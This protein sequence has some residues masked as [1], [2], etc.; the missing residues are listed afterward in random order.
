MRQR[1]DLLDPPVD[2]DGLSTVPN[3]GESIGHR[4]PRRR[5]C[6]TDK[7]LMRSDGGSVS[8]LHVEERRARLAVHVLTEHVGQPPI[9]KLDIG[10]HRLAR[11]IFDDQRVIGRGL[12][13]VC[14]LLHAARGDGF[15]RLQRLRGLGKLRLGV[16]CLVELRQNLIP[17]LFV[18]LGEVAKLLQ[19]VFVRRLGHAPC[20]LERRD[21]LGLGVFTGDLDRRLQFGRQFANLGIARDHGA[22]EFSRASRPLRPVHGLLLGIAGQAKHLDGA[23]PPV[24]REPILDPCGFCGLWRGR[25]RRFRGRRLCGGCFSLRGLCGLLRGLRGLC[26]RGCFSR[27][28]RRCRRIAA[29]NSRRAPSRSRGNVVCH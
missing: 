8:K 28:R 1:G 27:R 2:I 10:F 26:R 5:D 29:E 17:N 24:I 3:I 11:S 19:I 6:R 18:R 13:G 15:R 16:V 7:T 22:E 20:L 9:G 23:F 12:R 21:V 4:L 14:L 25:W